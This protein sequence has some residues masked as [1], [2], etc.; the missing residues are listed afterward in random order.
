MPTLDARTVNARDLGRIVA[1]V[2]ETAQAAWSQ[3]PDVTTYQRL[4]AESRFLRS[5]MNMVMESMGR[6]ERIWNADGMD[7]EIANHTIPTDEISWEMWVEQMVA[8][9]ALKALMETPITIMPAT[10]T[11]PAVT[12]TPATIISRIKPPKPYWGATPIE[13][14]PA[15]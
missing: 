13:Q 2:T 10:D 14:P 6:I 9:R 5:T 15:E 7:E 11:L 3:Q 1:E 8:F 4:V 12:Q